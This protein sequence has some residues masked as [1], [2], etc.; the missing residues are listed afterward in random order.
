MFK[1]QADVFKK[2]CHVHIDMETMATT[3]RPL[4]LQVGWTILKPVNQKLEIVNKNLDHLDIGEQLLRGRDID[5][6]TYDT[7]WKHQD[8]KVKESVFTP[9]EERVGIDSF[10]ENFLITIKNYTE[11][12]KQK[13]LWSN[14]SLDD[15]VWLRSLFDE[16]P[17]YEWPFSYKEPLCYRTEML[18]LKD[19][20]YV[21]HKNDLA[22]N[23]L[24]DAIF[25]SNVFIDMINNYDQVVEDINRMCAPKT[26]AEATKQITE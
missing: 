15:S 20:L 21:K 2:A 16:H 24:A 10:L 7:F 8:Q 14:G 13:F 6:K 11:G 5:Q 4:V 18:G 23:A 9:K 17:N 3:R 19:W 1:H 26:Q 25:Q 12:F 22:H